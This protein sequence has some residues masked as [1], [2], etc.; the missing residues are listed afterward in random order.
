MTA[1]AQAT[2]IRITMVFHRE[3]DGWRLVQSHTSVGVA[4]EQA[5]GQE[6]PI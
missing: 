5:S 1:D 6:L 3:G 4:N 2:V